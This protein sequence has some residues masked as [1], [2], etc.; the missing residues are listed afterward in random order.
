VL[1]FDAS[2]RTGVA[3]IVQIACS[4]DEPQQQRFDKVRIYITNYLGV[5]AKTLIADSDFSPFIF[6][7]RQTE[8]AVILYCR[9]VSKAGT[10]HDAGADRSK[11]LTLFLINTVPCRVTGAKATEITGGVQVDFDAGVETTITSYKIYRAALDAGFGAA[12]QVG[13]VVPTGAGRYTFLDASGNSSFEYYVVS[14][15]ARGD[16]LESLRAS[17]IRVVTS[18]NLPPNVASNTTN[19]ASV[20]S[21][22]AGASATIRIYGAASGVGTPWERVLGYGSVQYPAGQIT[23]KAYATVYYVF[24]NGKQYVALTSYPSAM[25]DNYVFAGKVTTVNAGGAGGVTGGGG[26]NGGSG[27]R[28]SL[29]T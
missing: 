19:K 10:E 13:T 2:K 4:F 7:L 16:G 23:G 18:A 28:W 12:V 26:V 20:D 6:N 8:E 21:I 3:G 1:S 5:A 24:W 14:S 15:N 25:P 17:T 9:G 29:T 22:D 27:G 11:N